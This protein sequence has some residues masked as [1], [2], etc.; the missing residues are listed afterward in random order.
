MRAS[1]VGTRPASAVDAAAFRARFPAL[2]QTAHLASCSLGARSVDLDAAMEAMLADMASEGAPWGRFE[3]QVTEARGR[4][5]SLIGARPQQ[6]AVVPN[7]SVGAYQIASTIDWSRRPRLVTSRVEFPSLGHVWLAQ[8]HNGADITFTASPD[9]QA[10]HLDERT[11]LVSVP[12]VDYRDARRW[13]V[14]HIADRAHA[15]GARVIVDAYQAVGVQPVDVTELGCDFLVA[16]SMKYLLGLPGVA[17]LYV[18]SPELV[19]RTPVLTGWF[20]RVNPFSFTPDQLDFPPEARK[21]ETGTP[22]VP[23]CYAA[24]AGLRLISS[25]DL[26]NVRDHVLGLSMLAT[27]QLTAAGER[28][29]AAPPGQRGAHIAIKDRDPVRLAA[30]LA[31]R[32]VIAS[33]RGDLLRLSFHF[34]NDTA[35]VE[36]AC[37][38]IAAYRAQRPES[39]IHPT[40]R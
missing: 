10:Q 5:A 35:D 34:Y 11:A 2:A 25:L 40:P 4:F 8:Q 26:V 36:A 16:G 12:L 6:V 30:F 13:P 32:R 1:L 31:R 28:V 18:K 20:G 3:D 23:A 15:L 17:F 27:D 24:A 39:N 14:R 19:D 38:A 7:A 29:Q 33:P 37:A 21:F 22:A 9:E